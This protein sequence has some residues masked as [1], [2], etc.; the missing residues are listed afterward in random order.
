VFLGLEDRE[1]F[2][3]GDEKVRIGRGRG[4][5]KSKE[6]ELEDVEITEAFLLRSANVGG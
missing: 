6:S 5:F 1:L 2:D 3:L 4:V